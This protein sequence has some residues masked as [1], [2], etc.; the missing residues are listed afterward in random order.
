[1]G[2]LSAGTLCCIDISSFCNIDSAKAAG[3]ALPVLDI[4]LVYL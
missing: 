4:L 1:M 2:H 3:F